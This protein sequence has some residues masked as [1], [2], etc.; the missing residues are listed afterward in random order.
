MQWIAAA[1]GRAAAAYE[2]AA[3]HV[4]IQQIE[5]LLDALS[6]K[7]A[8]LAAEPA[9]AVEATRAVIFMLAPVA[10]HLAEELWQRC[11]GPDLVASSAWPAAR[12]ACAVSTR[13]AGKVRA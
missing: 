6:R 2:R 13:V 1:E 7:H 3:P 10:P 12:E 11:G 4:A 9:V 5:R 8:E